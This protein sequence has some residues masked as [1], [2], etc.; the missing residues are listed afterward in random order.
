MSGLSVAAFVR[1]AEQFGVEGGAGPTPH[2]PE[3]AHACGLSGI[4]V[5]IAE[6]AEHLLGAAASVR[7]G[8]DVVELM[9]RDADRGDRDGDDQDCF[10]GCH[11]KRHTRPGPGS[12]R[13]FTY[14]LHEAV[15]LGVF[16][17]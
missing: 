4:A 8:E 11:V 7:L 12:T 9:D 15:P 5:R 14:R 6:H 2:T 3:L 16:V 1:Q 10:K 17:S 13:R